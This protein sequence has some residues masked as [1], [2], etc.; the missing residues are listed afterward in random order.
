MKIFYFF[1]NANINPIIS[2]HV[3]RPDVNGGFIQIL[4]GCMY[5]N[6]SN[7]QRRSN[8]S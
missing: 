3:K 1:T 5:E 6:D 4:K 2:Y 7:Y 8:Y